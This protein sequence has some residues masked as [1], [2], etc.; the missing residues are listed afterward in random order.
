MPPT[1]EVPECVAAFVKRVQAV[2]QGSKPPK[3]TKKRR[4]QAAA[5]AVRAVV[6]YRG[7]LA[8][9]AQRGLLR[10]CRQELM[11]SSSTIR[12]T[13][14]LK[15]VSASIRDVRLPLPPSA[16]FTLLFTLLFA[17]LFALPGVYSSILLLHNQAMSMGF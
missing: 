5:V 9:H 3:A 16:P 8:A 13:R 1:D 11:L 14:Q 15:T 4:L 7:T 12:S 10:A 6:V 2:R 17:P